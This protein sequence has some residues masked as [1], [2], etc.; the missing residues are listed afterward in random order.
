M[1]IVKLSKQNPISIQVMGQK[2]SLTF[3]LISEVN[4][5]NFE[6]LE[7]LLIK[8]NILPDVIGL[9]ETRIKINALNYISNQLAGFYFLHFDSAANSGG[10]GKFI[11]NNVDFVLRED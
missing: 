5:K 6:S 9:T 1:I 4:K 3:I 11:K 10:V 8:L 2:T 7:Q